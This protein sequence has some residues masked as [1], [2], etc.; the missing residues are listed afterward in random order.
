MKWKTAARELRDNI[1]LTEGGI[2]LSAC[3]ELTAVRT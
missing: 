3:T 2:S 1:V